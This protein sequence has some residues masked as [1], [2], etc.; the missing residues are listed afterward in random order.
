MSAVA[1]SAFE[2]ETAR[3]R[4]RPLGEGDEEL[5]CRLYT[6]PETMRFIGPPMTP[7]RAARSFRKA[8]NMLRKQPIEWVFVVVVDKSTGN[9]LGICGIPAF[10]DT[11]QRLEVGMMLL[12]EARARGFSEEG[13]AGLIDHLFSILPV[14]EV[15]VE[16]S[17]E[18]TAAE[19]LTI[20]I[21][22]LPIT[23]ITPRTSNSRTRSA[24]R[25]TW[26]VPGSDA[27]KE[28][29]ARHVECCSLSAAVG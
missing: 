11:A 6:D 8:L 13:L 16:Y 14:E 26:C 17:P 20:S 27:A 9:R 4:M 28:G 21:G 3:L 18:H 19:R 5:F 24:Q 10:S 23:H 7:E 29:G 15:W 12:A 2:F 1:P 25:E 22:L